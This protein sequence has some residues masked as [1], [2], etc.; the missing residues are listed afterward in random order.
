[1]AKSRLTR[2]LFSGKVW[3]FPLFASLFQIFVEYVR[4]QERYEVLQGLLLGE[5][6][7]ALLILAA[8]FGGKGLS[9][10]GSAGK[11]VLPLLLWALVASVLSGNPSASLTTY[12]DVLK[13]VGVFFFIVATIQNKEQLYVL[14][15]WYMAIAFLH[16]NFS[17]R[18]WAAAGFVGSGGGAYVGSGF[19]QNPNDYGAGMAAL[20]GLSLGLAV[21]DPHALG[22]ISMKWIHRVNTVLFL[23]GV[24]T[25][26]SRGA[27]VATLAGAVF[28]MAVA[29]PGGKKKIASMVVIAGLVVGF[30]TLLS[31]SQSARFENMGSEEDE[32]AQ[33]RRRT[34]QVALMVIAD[35]PVVGVGVGQ[36][37]P[38]AIR[39][40]A[41][42]Q[43]FVQHNILLQAASDMGLPG[44]ALLGAILWGF[45]LDQKKVMARLT[46][47]P[48]PL[49]KAIAV[50]LNV[51]MFSFLVAGQFIT[52]LFYPFLWSLLIISSALYRVTEA[53]KTRPS[54]KWPRPAPGVA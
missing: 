53:P 33:D 13:V 39:Y 4:P 1:M 54:R 47:R 22:R 32:S 26:T 34:W 35:N 38:V 28:Y 50:G 23:V 16:T 14:V 19:L 43:I 18:M 36:F 29:V 2:V 7:F 40:P 17:F 20:W 9:S 11:W 5:V 12:S 3:T 24:L 41:Q 45:Y 25:S 21:H 27:A 44:L 51:S 46:A 37:V 8:L 10:G 15:L 6:S 52:V 49:L 48:D 30:L 31:D 42:G